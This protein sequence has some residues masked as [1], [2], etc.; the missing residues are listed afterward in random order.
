MRITKISSFVQAVEVAEEVA[1]EGAERVL[2]RKVLEEV[3]VA[4]AVVSVSL[5]DTV[6]GEVMDTVEEVTAVA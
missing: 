3:E 2:L 5:L 4:V 6:E 1:E